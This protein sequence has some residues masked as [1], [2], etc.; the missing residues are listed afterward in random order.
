ME[1]KTDKGR[2]RETFTRSLNRWGVANK[3][4][5]TNFIRQTSDRHDMIR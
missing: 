1:E 4:N 3:I 2:L 5:N